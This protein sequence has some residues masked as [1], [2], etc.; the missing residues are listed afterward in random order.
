MSSKISATLQVWNTLH[1]VHEIFKW[2][3][4]WLCGRDERI[5]K[6][7]GGD[8]LGTNEMLEEK[9]LCI[10]HMYVCIWE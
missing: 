6:G 4:I 8:L 2:Y 10:I 3:E 7:R 1:Y 5:P 9:N